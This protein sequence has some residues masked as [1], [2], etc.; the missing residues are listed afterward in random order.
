MP[1]D[2]GPGQD[3][4][5]RASRPSQGEVQGHARARGEVDEIDRLVL[6]VRATARGR[7]LL[8]EGRARRVARLAEDLGRLGQEERRV[9]ARAAEILGRLTRP[10][11]RPA[12]S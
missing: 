9:V 11:S 8:E 4:T 3:Q 2:A 7:R 10:G 5:A 6:R 12:G 1:A